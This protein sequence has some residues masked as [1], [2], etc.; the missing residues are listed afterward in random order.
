MIKVDLKH[1]NPYYVNRSKEYEDLVSGIN[2]K[3]HDGSIHSDW[4]GWLDL[5]NQITDG[6]I[7]RVET[8]AARIRA[9]SD[10][11]LVVGIGGSYLG[12]AAGID[13]LSNYFE[14]NDTEVIFVGHNISSQYIAE[15][16]KY[17]ENKDFSI[18]VISKSGTTLEP[19][20][21]FRIFK[22]ILESKYGEG[23][24]ERI[25]ATTDPES[26]AL[27]Q[28]SEGM[29]YETYSIPRNIGGRYSVLTPVGLLPM[30]V[31]G[32][33]IKEV[34]AGAKEA[35]VDSSKSLDENAAYQYAVIRDIYYNEGKKIE[36]VAGYD[37]KFK[38]LFEW[39]KQLFMESEGKQNK[40]MFMASC[41]F[42]TDLHSLGQYIQEGPRHMI[43]TVFAVKNVKDDILIKS[44]E[45]NLDGLNYLTG[46]SVSQVNSMAMLG[47]INAHVDGGVP[48][49]I[50]ELPTIDAKSFGYM[51]YFFMKSCAMSSI[52]LD[53]DPFN[54]PGVE[55]YKKNMFKLLGK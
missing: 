33:D 26:G 11:L 46:K 14:K 37:P 28:L 39:M 50:L 10:V 24:K 42:T 3:L 53:V 30:A 7:D 35:F 40:G 5:P 41:N 32:I 31:A 38:M 47:T 6:T 2:M 45:A 49:I 55:A 52:L 43:E 22:N 36:I 18:N 27:R 34:I 25:I 13:M 12:S 19:A 1:L 4:T 23:A 17:V 20:L 29:G 9:N 15:L 44:D 48:T 21:A 8:T 51:A 54:Q 16:A